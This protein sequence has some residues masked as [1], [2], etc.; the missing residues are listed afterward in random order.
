MDKNPV[1]E[2]LSRGEA[3]VGTWCVS[4]D[5]TVVEVLA[6]SGLDWITLDFEHNAI[7]VSTAVNC[8]RAAQGT[9]V[10]LFARVP[11]NDPVWIKRVLDIG[12]LG[13]V[14][15]DV[16]TPEE[17]EKAVKASRYRPQGVRGIGSTRGSLIYGSDYYAK[18][19]DLVMV[20]VMIEDK[21]AVEIADKIVSVP[22][23]DIAFIG[24]NDLASSLGVPVGLDNKHPDHV[25]A[26]AKVLAACKKASVP[27]GIHCTGGEEISRRIAQGFQ[28]MPIGSDAR[29]IKVA[30][31]AEL[32]TAYSSSDGASVGQSKEGAKTFY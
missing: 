11:S 7:D 9:N 3:A 22:G 15:P 19:N 10:P 6:R 18:A 23:V 32:R 4:A 29:V 31:E 25:A 1:R 8:L 2:K 5:P 12:F 27:A 30:F 17:A 16:R 26:V 24:P 20:A 21:G 28:W 14:I 13:V